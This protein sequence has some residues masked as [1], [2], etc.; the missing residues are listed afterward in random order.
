MK[1]LYIVETPLQLLCAFE[2]IQRNSLGNYVLILRYSGVGH[3]DE[4]MYN[5]ALLLKLDFVILNIR[6]GNVVRDTFKQSF[7]IIHLLSSS[8]K[9]IYIGS[10]FSRWQMSFYRGVRC[11][12]TYLLDDGMATFLAQKKMAKSKRVYDLFTYLEVDAIKS[13]KIHKHNFVNLRKRYQLGEPTGQ[14]IFVGQILVEMEF[15]TLKQ[16]KNLVSEVAKSCDELI[17]IPHRSVTKS[18]LDEITTI[19]NVSILKPDSCIEVFLLEN[20]IYPQR[21]YSSISSALVTLSEIFV[22]SKVISII[23]NDI[24][25]VNA[26]HFDEI[27]DSLNKI[28]N[29]EVIEG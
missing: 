4:Q 24:S 16:Y 18:T 10:Y 15:L 11:N 27:V 8:Y 23:P 14:N 28:K 21:V 19:K 25:R 9:N 26:E 29:I 13:Q 1:D 2:A 6:L 22:L 5:I 7:K 3:N 12:N 17:Y 20:N